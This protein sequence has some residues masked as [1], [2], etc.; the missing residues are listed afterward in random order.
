MAQNSNGGFGAKPKIIRFRGNDRLWPIE[1][2][3][4]EVPTNPK[5]KWLL[6]LI[7][8]QSNQ[9]FD[10]RQASNHQRSR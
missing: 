6:S 7:L 3:C 4:L 10:S 5:C 8:S 1:A 9:S 2:R